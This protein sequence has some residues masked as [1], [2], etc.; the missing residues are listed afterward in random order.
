MMP[1]L[2]RGMQL[3]LAL[4]SLDR[5][6]V[7]AELLHNFSALRNEGRRFHFV[8]FAQCAQLLEPPLQVA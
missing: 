8:L 1:R 2:L 3:Q 6:L 7:A 4:L 5:R